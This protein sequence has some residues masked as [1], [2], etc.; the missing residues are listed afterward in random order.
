ML[1]WIFFF[2]FVAIVEVYAF[3][4]LKTITRTKWISCHTKLSHYWPFCI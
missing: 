1:R 2:L 4:A 3:Q